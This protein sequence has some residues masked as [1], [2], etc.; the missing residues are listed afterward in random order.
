M[1][2][3][4]CYQWFD[5][6]HMKRNWDAARMFCD[7]IGARLAIVPNQAIQNFL[8]SFNHQLAVAGMKDYWI[9]ASNISEYILLSLLLR[10]SALPV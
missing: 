7:S 5:A 8:S 9:G 10:I 4:N 1:Y 6:A 3:D 2:E